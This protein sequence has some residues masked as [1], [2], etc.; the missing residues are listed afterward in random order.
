MYKG[1]AFL[2]WL[3]SLQLVNKCSCLTADGVIHYKTDGNR[4]SGDIN[5]SLGN[6]VLMCGMIWSYC[7]EKGIPCELINNGDDCTV[8]IDA[9][10]LDK[11]MD[12]LEAWFLEMGFRMTVEE[13]VY[14]FEHIEFCQCHFVNDGAQYIACRNYPIALDKDSHSLLNLPTENLRQRWFRSTADQGLALASGIPI[15]QAFY[16]AFERSAGSAQSTP[17][18][19]EYDSGLWWLSRGME[20]QVREISPDARISFFKAFGVWPG[21][22]EAMERQLAS[23]TQLST[24]E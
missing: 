1:D 20:A 17:E 8:I 11:F 9:D 23:A 16:Q 4:M 24:R 5:T 19:T 14:E 21:V 13:P 2:A 12:G 6:C 10:D 22:Q 18:T 7:D 15:F 3:L